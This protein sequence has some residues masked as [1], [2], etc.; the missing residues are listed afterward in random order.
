L[1]D[2]AADE[3]AFRSF[4]SQIDIRGQRGFDEG[5]LASVPP[6]SSAAPA[7]SSAAH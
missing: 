3:P 7:P 5:K 6:A 2:F 1:D 4:L